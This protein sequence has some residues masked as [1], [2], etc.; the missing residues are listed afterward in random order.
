MVAEVVSRCG[1]LERSEFDC[2]SVGDANLPETLD[3]RV[4]HRQSLMLLKRILRST[5]RPFLHDRRTDSVCLQVLEVRI[6]LLPILAQPPTYPTMHRSI[7]MTVSSTDTLRGLFDPPTSP[8]ID[9]SDGRRGED[10]RGEKDAGY[11][12]CGERILDFDAECTD[13]VLVLDL[14]ARCAVGIQG[15]KIE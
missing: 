13:S 14:F 8:R 3:D 4:I 12:S 6:P 11:T 1:G 2:R 10:F 9:A 5:K 7:I 15:N